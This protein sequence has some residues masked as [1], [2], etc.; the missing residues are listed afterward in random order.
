[1]I[2]EV[3]YSENTTESENPKCHKS[4]EL[5]LFKDFFMSTFNFGRI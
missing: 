1:M 5:P 3:E 4:K 2:A